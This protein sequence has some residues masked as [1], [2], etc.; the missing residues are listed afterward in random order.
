MEGPASTPDGGVPDAPASTPANAMTDD[1]TVS[2][3]VA[4]A[5]AA[6]AAAV[7]A[8]PAAAERKSV[9]VRRWGW[10]GDWGVGFFEL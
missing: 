8:E 9:Q 4:V 2:A 5:A 6:A 7:A 10:A 1:A 3:A